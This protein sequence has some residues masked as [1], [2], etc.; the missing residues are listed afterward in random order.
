MIR[1]SPATLGAQRSAA[2]LVAA[3]RRS[4]AP[5]PAAR[6]SAG[7]ARASEQCVPFA[8]LGQPPTAPL[9]HGALIAL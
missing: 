1:A 7:A 5:R 9:A 6:R 8:P 3:A 4:R 2:P